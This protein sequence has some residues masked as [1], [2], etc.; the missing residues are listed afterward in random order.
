[1]EEVFAL[2]TKRC[3][4]ISD[5]PGHRWCHWSIKSIFGESRSLIPLFVFSASKPLTIFSMLFSSDGELWWEFD[6]KCSWGGGVFTTTVGDTDIGR[7]VECI[8]D[9]C[10]LFRGLLLKLRTVFVG[11]SNALSPDDGRLYGAK[12]LF[13]LDDG[14]VPI[15]LL[16][17][18][19]WSGGRDAPE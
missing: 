7:C 1:M 2:P 19:R 11:G 18:F 4:T 6:V 9:A 14:I 16:L 5:S 12:R 17:P 8:G 15:E 10:G 13:A 3:T